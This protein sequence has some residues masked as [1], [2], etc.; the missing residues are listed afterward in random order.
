MKKST[1][2]I[3]IAV[4]IALLFAPRYF[5]DRSKEKKLMK[6]AKK[7]EA[8]NVKVL[9]METDKKPIEITL[10]SYLEA[11]HVTPIL[12][13]V[14]G[15]LIDFLVDIGDKVKKGQLL[16]TIDTP[17]IDEELAQALGQLASLI[18]KEEIARITAERWTS[19]YE[20]NPETVSKE[21]V[22][23]TVAAYESASADVIAAQANVDR[24]RAL[25]E[26]NQVY[27][28][29][30]GVITKRKEIDYGTLVI[31]GGFDHPVELF[32][33]AETNIMR[34]FVDV[35]QSLFYLVKDGMP[36]EATLWQYPGKA[37]AGIID[38]NASAL[39][40]QARTLLTQVNIEN[41]EG[42]LMPGLYTQVKFTFTPEKPRFII[43][44]GAL[45]IRSGPPLVAVVDHTTVHLKQVEIGLDNG[46]WFEIIDGICA[47]DEVIVNPTDRIREGT[48]VNPVTIS[49]EEKKMMF[50]Q[51]T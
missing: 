38:R 30:D 27:A 40:P 14:N 20:Y 22:D 26:F 10:P 7:T 25:Q 50:K 36:A 6:K 21:E 48:Q 11:I 33:L 13:R 12:A 47:G 44:V 43:P 3:G 37:F 31:A 51:K 4:I 28:P 9:K 16:A 34:A 41:K 24:I 2:F 19:I 8:I 49:A 1:I 18:A 23:R 39:D 15:Y 35:P 29:F 46:N 42:V 32:E 45:I 17:E 5:S